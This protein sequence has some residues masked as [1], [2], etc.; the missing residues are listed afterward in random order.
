M[1][2]LNRGYSVVITYP[3]TPLIWMSFSH[4]GGKRGLKLC[5]HGCSSRP[6]LKFLDQFA[7]LALLPSVPLGQ[8]LICAGAEIFKATSQLAVHPLA[9]CYGEWCRL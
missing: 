7:G 1:N 4:C 9:H 8:P 3:S 2:S 6:V 5:S